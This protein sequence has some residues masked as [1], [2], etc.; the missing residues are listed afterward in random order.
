MIRLGWLGVNQSNIF[1]MAANPKSKH[2]AFNFYSQCTVMDSNSNSVYEGKEKVHDEAPPSH[3]V[4]AEMD[5]YIQWF[6]E[7]APNGNHT[8]PALTR[9]GMAHLYF[10]SIHPYRQLEQHQR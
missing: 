9:A 3:R 10:E 6:N 8:L 7:T 2:A 1:R 4:P 5:A